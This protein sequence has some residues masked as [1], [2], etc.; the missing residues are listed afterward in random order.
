MTEVVSVAAVVVAVDSLITDVSVVT[1]LESAAVVE[2]TDVVV[3]AAS[4]TVV[5]V[6][7]SVGESDVATVSTLLVAAESSVADV[8]SAVC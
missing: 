7:A 6:S 1:E 8:A 3:V 4:L 5:V 2:E